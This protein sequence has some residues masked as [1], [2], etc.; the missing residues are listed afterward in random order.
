MNEK[1]TYLRLKQQ[2]MVFGP[3]LHFFQVGVGLR[4]TVM[5][6]RHGAGALSI[7]GGSILF[8]IHPCHFP[9]SLLIISLSSPCCFPIISSPIAVSILI[10]VYLLS[11]QSSSSL[12]LSVG[13]YHLQT[14]P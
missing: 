5:G 1:K 3:S 4:A 11:H 7:C 13:Y 9:S 12:S 6:R 8:V 14:T 10:V 2:L